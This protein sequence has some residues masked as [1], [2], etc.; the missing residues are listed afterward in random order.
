MKKAVALAPEW[1]IKP[2]GNTCART[3]RAFA[4]KEAFWTLLF[5][6]GTDFHREDVC[7]EAWQTIRQSEE[8]KPFSFWK[9][10]YTPPPPPEPEPLGKQSA[11]QMLRRHMEELA[12]ASRHTCFILAL[13]LERK[14]L[15]RQTDAR[16]DANG[17]ILIYEHTKTGEVFVIR[18]P[19]LRLDQI[20]EIQREVFESLASSEF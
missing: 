8:T 14:R 9:S 6:N 16:N 3:G 11:E 17:R 20:E 10:R 4:D 19:E 1:E 5:D 18:D 12:P 2:R 15:L 13:M 7:E